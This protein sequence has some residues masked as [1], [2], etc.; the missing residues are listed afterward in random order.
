LSTRS[1]SCHGYSRFSLLRRYSLTLGHRDA[2]SLGEV[3][4]SY[5]RLGERRRI[6]GQR[7]HGSGAAPMPSCDEVTHVRFSNDAWN[8][9]IPPTGRFDGRSVG[10]TEAAQRQPPSTAEVHVLRG[11]L[12][13]L[14]SLSRD[15]LG[16]N[17]SSAEGWLRLRRVSNRDHP[18][19][20]AYLSPVFAVR[21]DWRRGRRRPPSAVAGYQ[22]RGTRPPIFRPERPF[23]SRLLAGLRRPV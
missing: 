13:P 1:R 10:T 3:R 9:E 16:S 6:D 5:I 21:D 2:V 4:Q 20:E 11:L 22:L 18:S 19:D 23:R 17:P 8:G 15:A 14:G 12:G 7:R